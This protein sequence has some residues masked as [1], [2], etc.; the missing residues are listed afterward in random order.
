MWAGFRDR[1]QTIR[2]N[3]QMSGTVAGCPVGAAG[4]T[5]WARVKAAVTGPAGG[6]NKQNIYHKK[7]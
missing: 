2:P 4:P 5:H 1:Q 7:Q 3:Q 6:V